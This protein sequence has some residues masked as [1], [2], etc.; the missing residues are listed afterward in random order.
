[1]EKFD[2]NLDLRA[3]RVLVAIVRTGSL[4]AAA[5]G[6]GVNQSTVSYTLAKLREVFGDALFVRAGRGVIPTARCE[7]IVAEAERLLLDFT[8]LASPPEFDAATSQETVVIS[9]NFY[10]RTVLLPDLLRAVRAEAPGL[11]MSVIQAGIRGHRQLLGNECDLLIS[12]LPAEHAGLYTRVLFAERYACFVDRDSRAAREG[13]SLD[14]YAAADHIAINYEGGW[15]PFYRDTLKSLNIDI[16]P[17]LELPSFGMAH[18]LIAGTDLVLTA[19]SGL[20]PAMAESCVR[21]EAPFDCA[22]NVHL[23]WSGRAHATPVNRW[24]RDHVVR[25]ARKVAARP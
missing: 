10:E 20:A 4:T 16:V 12:P 7:H 24:M 21:V 18:R 19:P 1:M 8:R 23:F 13:L 22:F 5:Q 11:R 25:A 9:C 15:K 17:K 3:L 6:L 14:A 2:G